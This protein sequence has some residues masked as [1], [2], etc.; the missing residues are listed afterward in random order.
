MKPV[1]VFDYDGTIHNTLLIYEESLKETINWLVENNYTRPVE[2]SKETAASF[3]GIN[4][5]DMWNIFMP[6]LPDEIKEAASLRTGS[7]MRMRILSHKARWYENAE[8][9]LMSLKKEGY[10]MYI[11][12]NCK[13]AYREANW[14]AFNMARYF[15]D[16]IDCESYGFAP[17]T[18]IIKACF[19][20]QADNLI[21]IGDRDKDIQCAK[22]Y[23]A[24]SIGCL[25]GY[26]SKEELA[27]ASYFINDI[28]ELLSVLSVIENE[29]NS[30]C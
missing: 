9:T 30:L 16:F 11:L 13:T 1:L 7:N 8:A 19:K 5:K 10:K 12:S 3:L 20:E 18:D 21:V 14:E 24:R 15:T 23:G 17:K 6:D 22:A 27:D 28:S 29:H 4:S 26:G 25:Y 2:V